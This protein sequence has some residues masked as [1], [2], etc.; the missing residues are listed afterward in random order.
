MNESDFITRSIQ[1]VELNILNEFVKLCEKHTLKYFLYG[2]T[3]IGA[4]R[5]K[6]FIP[7]DD[8]IDIAMPRE[9][10]EKF[11]EIGKKELP[12]HL[13]LQHHTTDKGYYLLFAKVRDNNSTFIE[14]GTRHI[15]MHKGIYID[16]FPLDTMPENKL[17]RIIEISVLR[18]LCRIFAVK[19]LYYSSCLSIYKKIKLFIFKYMPVNSDFIIYICDRI[20]KSDMNKNSRYIGDLTHSPSEK[21]VY[22]KAWF[23]ETMKFEFESVQFDGPAGYH[24]YLKYYYG[25]YMQ[26]K[27]K[28]VHSEFCDPYKPY[29]EFM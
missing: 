25:D 24:E 21:R 23:D 1:Q 19:K 16:I 10:Y 5:H 20:C 7:W 14:D 3:L 28:P 29:N 6:G 8:D 26:E 18:V 11:L 4:V 12:S 17:L 27:R 15:N 2:G 13:F 22:K 9:D